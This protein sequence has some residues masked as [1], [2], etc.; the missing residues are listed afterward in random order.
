MAYE[1]KNGEGS[2][3]ANKYKEH[4]NQPDMKGKLITKEGQVLSVSGWKKVSQNGTEYIS[5]ACQEWVEKS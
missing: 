2:L 5:L 3:F 1:T 4:D